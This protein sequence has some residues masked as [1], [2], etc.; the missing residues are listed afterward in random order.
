MG[1]RTHF[2]NLRHY[3]AGKRGILGAD[4]VGRGMRSKLNR[5]QMRGP[6]GRTA[7]FLPP[8][9]PQDGLQCGCRELGVHWQ[10]LHLSTS[11][12]ARYESRGR[13]VICTMCRVVQCPSLGRQSSFVR[14]AVSVLT[15]EIKD[16]SVPRRRKR[17][18]WLTTGLKDGVFL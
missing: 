3:W 12:A 8:S 5:T 18:E 15:D 6:C 1:R 13:G 11:L 16:F 2:V 14:A 4:L 7:L 17:R 9:S 10:P